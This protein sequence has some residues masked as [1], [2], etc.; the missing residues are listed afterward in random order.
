MP[1]A[2]IARRGAYI[3]LVPDDERRA[4]ERLENL[5]GRARHLE[6]IAGRQVDEIASL[7][8]R[9]QLLERQVREL[10]A[11]R[12]ALARL[13]ADGDQAFAHLVAQLAQRDARSKVQVARIRELEGLLK[14]RTRELARAERGRR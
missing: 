1:A 2:Y 12:D 8:A 9:L 13:R 7:K 11:E 10:G 5:Q 3:R 14:Q 6:R 4:R